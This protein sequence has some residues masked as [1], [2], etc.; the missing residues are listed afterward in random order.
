MSSSWTFRPGLSGMNR[1]IMDRLRKMILLQGALC[2]ALFTGACGESSPAR[3]PGPPSGASSSAA[4]GQTI[5]PLAAPPGSDERPP[6]AGSLGR[7]IDYDGLPSMQPAK[8]VNVSVDTLF[9]QDIKDPIERVKRVETAVLEMRRDLDASLPAIKRLVA[10]EKDIQLL[11]SQLQTLLNQEPAPQAPAPLTPED[12]SL[13]NEFDSAGIAPREDQAPEPAG[14]EESPAPAAPAITPPNAPERMAQS[15]PATAPPA[16]APPPA[17][18]PDQSTVAGLR[19]LGLRLGEH[20]DKTRIVIDLSGPVTYRHDLDNGEKI[21][22]I[23]LD[24]ANWAGPASQTLSSPLIQ[25]YSTQP[26][27]NGGGTRLI[28][29]L[30]QATAVTSESL[31]GPEGASGWRLLLDLKK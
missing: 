23:E 26:M 7:G 19:G 16:A 2:L 10:I 29:S 13:A 6:E 1:C 12:T 11:T 3:G 8:G 30:K 21:L 14:E 5:A 20:D 17:P 9:E 15:P 24:K 22:V 27:E 18:P 4:S 28:I 31:L 25:S